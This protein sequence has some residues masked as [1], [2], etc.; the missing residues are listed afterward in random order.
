M[1]GNQGVW[2]RGMWINTGKWAKSVIFVSH[3]NTPQESIIVEEAQ[4]TMQTR[5]LLFSGLRHLPLQK[6]HMNGGKLQKGPTAQ[7][8]TLPKLI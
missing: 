6:W 7:T 8:P 1:V 4:N 2:A 5:L 3:I